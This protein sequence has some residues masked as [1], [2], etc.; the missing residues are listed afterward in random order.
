MKKKVVTFLSVA[1]L[2][3]ARSV[4][5]QTAAAYDA[6]VRGESPNFFF[7]LN[8]TLVDSV[9]GVVALSSATQVYTTDAW[10]NS[11][12]A[13]RLR[14]SSVLDIMTNGADLFAGGGAA[15]GDPGAVGKGSL[16][17]LF[18]TLT[19]APGGER[20]LFNQ[21]LGGGASNQFTLF[22]AGSGA[23]SD[24]GALK[25][26]VG[27]VTNTILAAGNVAFSSWYY[28]GVTYDEARDAGEV[29][30][31]LG[32]GTNLTSGVMDIGNNSV[33]G[34]NFPVAFGGRTAGSATLN[35]DNPGDGAMDE[36]AIWNRELN[37][38]EITSQFNSITGVPEPSG[39]A[40]MALGLALAIGSISAAVTGHFKTSRSRSNQNQ[41]PEVI[42]SEWAVHWHQGS[43]PT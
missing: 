5:G 36:I 3:L 17:F 29:R 38:G 11:T 24:P 18:R 16:T 32:S 7:T 23:A 10:G 35:F 2:L 13:G 1:A 8:N 26:R 27:D 34:D 40:I 39:G 4:S 14:Q 22:F 19:G 31:Y 25:L 33:V 12:S 21:S 28:F 30:W 6:A 20:W 42:Y 43:S 37:S 15:G 41:P 9:G